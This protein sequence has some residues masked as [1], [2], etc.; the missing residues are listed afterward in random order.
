MSNY[1]LNPLVDIAFKKLFGVDEN[2]DLLIDLINAIVSKEDQIIDLQIKNPY[3]AK[4]FQNDKMSI[5]DIKAQGVNKK[6]YIIE[7]QLMNQDFFDS[8]ALYYWARVYQE[9]LTIRMNYD[10][11]EKVISINFLNFNCLDEDNY[12]NIYKIMNTKTFNNYPNNHLEIHFVE[13]K[14]YNNSLSTMLDKWTNFLKFDYEADQLPSEMHVPSIE[15]AVNVLATMNLNNDEREDYENRLKW[16][17]DEE[18][19]LL[20]AKNA[21][22]AEGL[23]QGL[24]QGLEQGLEQGQEKAKLEIAR[25]MLKNNFSVEDIIKCTGLEREK[26]LSAK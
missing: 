4:S 13:L 6:W 16:M 14:K 26:I 7:V 15:K 20:T 11:L 22:L 9:Q 19:A 12:H 3:N 21:G 10:I 8:R 2:K 1:T 23:E 18:M 17:R 25:Q 24:A 5:L